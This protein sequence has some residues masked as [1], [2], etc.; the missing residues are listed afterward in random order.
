MH[1][2]LNASPLSPMGEDCPEIGEQKSIKVLL[3]LK[4]TQKTNTSI[5]RYAD[6][7]CTQTHIV[8]MIPNNRQE[9][10]GAQCCGRSISV[11]EM[12]PSRDANSAS[13]ST[14]SGGV[15]SSNR[16][17]VTRQMLSCATNTLILSPSRSES[18]GEASAEG[19]FHS[20]RG[21]IRRLNA[22]NLRKTAPEK[23]EAGVLVVLLLDHGSIKVVVSSAPAVRPQV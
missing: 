22:A 19:G 15:C 13:I 6:I 1:V 17:V 14:G 11:P 21:L 7:I 4:A 23:I 2:L 18:G 3:A 10:R 8:I 5:G 16:S 20:T 9:G 12:I